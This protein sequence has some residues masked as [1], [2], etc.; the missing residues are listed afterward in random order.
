MLIPTYIRGET[1]REELLK[2]ARDYLNRVTVEELKRDLAECWVDGENIIKNKDS[3]NHNHIE[4]SIEE[5]HYFKD[6]NLEWLWKD[7]RCYC[8]I[9]SIEEPLYLKGENSE[10]LR[11]YILTE[12]VQNIRQIIMDDTLK[13]VLKFLEI[14]QFQ[15]YS[16]MPEH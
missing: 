5:P 11:K 6:R 12:I 14:M 10:S 15:Y 3:Y 2:M 9:H 4:Y 16:P 13:C 7:S 1:M 8:M